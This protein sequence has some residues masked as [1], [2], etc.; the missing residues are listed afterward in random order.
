MS[1]VWDMCCWFGCWVVGGGK[2]VFVL[3]HLCQERR[4]VGC[5]MVGE[6][7]LVFE[8]VPRMGK[9]VVV[10]FTFAL[11]FCSSFL[12]F[13][14]F[15]WF[16]LLSE[17]SHVVQSSDVWLDGSVQDVKRGAMFCVERW[18]EGFSED[19]RC[20]VGRGYSPDP[21]IVLHIIM[22]N[23]VMSDVNRSRMVVKVW[24]RC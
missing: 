21:H 15:E 24:L 13:R 4:D 2:E 7:I 23:F 10:S 1:L 9:K 17:D 3:V 20:V 18:L 16:F 22:F 12:L 11:S 8:G 6:V 5:L 14:W 19:I